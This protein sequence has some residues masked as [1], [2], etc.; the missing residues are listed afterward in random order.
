VTGGQLLQRVEP[1]YPAFARTQRYQ[2]DV[3]LAVK[4]T[5]I[6]TVENIR[7]VSG[8]PMLSAAAIEAVKRWKYEPYRLNG[9]PQEIDTTVT[10]KFK[11]PK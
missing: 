4:I 10:V 6:G 8:N 1:T 9:Q 2:G 3:V 11:L 7:R 5:K